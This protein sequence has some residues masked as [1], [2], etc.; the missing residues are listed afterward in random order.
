MS[1]K[2]KPL[3]Y[4]LVS[5]AFWGM[6]AEASNSHAI[7]VGT[8]G[9]DAGYTINWGERSGTGSWGVSSD[10]FLGFTLKS[11][12]N[13]V[14]AGELSRGGNVRCIGVGGDQSVGNEASINRDRRGTVIEAIRLDL[15]A[16]DA[17]VGV[18]GGEG[19]TF[20][21]IQRIVFDR[22]AL[23]KG[24]QV[25]ISGFS[26]NPKAS[27]KGKRPEKLVYDAARGRLSF[28]TTDA[29]GDLGIIEFANLN[30]TLSKSGVSLVFSNENHGN[31]AYGLVGW[32]Y[33]ANPNA[34]TE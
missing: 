8:G 26:E 17:T 21:G 33:V 9:S 29:S 25:S 22:L 7:Y 3:S 32:H 30:A 11:M 10:S 5:A 34:L 13:G 19:M 27:W 28:T 15:P 20:A 16:K 6:S 12:I 23:G 14:E 2:I 1:G 24:S 31:N 18:I 4:L